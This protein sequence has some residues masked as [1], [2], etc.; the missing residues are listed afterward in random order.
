MAKTLSKMTKLGWKR[1]IIQKMTEAGTYDE[2]FDPVID[3]LV[4]ILV[5]RD[6][7]YNQY[8]K[9]GSHPLVKVTSDRGAENMRKNPLLSIWQELIKDALQYWRDLGLTPA[10]LKK[11]NEDAMKTTEVSPLESILANLEA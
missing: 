6:R 9:E 10:G 11:I 8:V 2:V 5:E 4:D 3:T 7:V 1:L